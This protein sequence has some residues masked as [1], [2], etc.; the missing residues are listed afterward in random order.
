MLKQADRKVLDELKFGDPKKPGT[1]IRLE[2]T[3]NGRHYITLW[4]SL[5]KRFNPM[6]RYD[7][8]TNWTKWKALHAR[9]YA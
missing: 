9:L 5:T 4:S 2:Q 1:W 7:I 8:E 3:E 6:Y